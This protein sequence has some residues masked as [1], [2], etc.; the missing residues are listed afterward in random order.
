MQQNS[1]EMYQ[2]WVVAHVLCE[3]E[4]ECLP[5]CEAS[6]KSLGGT[7]YRKLRSLFRR[8]LAYTFLCR[9]GRLASPQNP[10]PSY[11]FSVHSPSLRE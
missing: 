2:S 8:R 11:G 10:H 3:V 7:L 4:A 5:E 9:G 1:K 6:W